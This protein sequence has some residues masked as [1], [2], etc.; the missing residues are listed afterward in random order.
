MLDVPRESEWHGAQDLRTVVH[1]LNTTKISFCI[2]FGH[3]LRGVKILR[4][5][6]PHLFNDCEEIP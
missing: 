1:L 2:Q 4:R 5:F 3:D 6:M